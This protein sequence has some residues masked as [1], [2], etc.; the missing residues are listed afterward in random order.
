[1]RS[2]ETMHA[3]SRGALTVLITLGM[4]LAPGVAVADPSGSGSSSDGSSDGSPNAPGGDSPSGTAPTDSG[5]GAGG[6]PAP[7]DPGGP[8]ASKLGS[9]P[10]EMSPIDKADLAKRLAD[11]DAEV[12]EVVTL[13]QQV[14]SDPGFLPEVV[15]VVDD[16]ADVLVT[17]QQLVH[18]L[19]DQ[20]GITAPAA[21]FA[22]ATAIPPN[23][24][25][26]SLD[27]LMLQVNTDRQ[28]W[29]DAQVRAQSAQVKANS[30]N[31]AALKDKVQ[32]PNLSQSEKDA[33][34]AEIDSLTSA[35]QSQM[36][37]FQSTMDQYT[38]TSEGLA[39]WLAKDAQSLNTLTGN[40]R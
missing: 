3:L 40:L 22:P 36:I 39:N 29:L 33:I 27:Q 17:E 2:G 28:S 5:Q 12:A 11:I 31:L 25:N 18:A 21:P 37:E 20:Q 30:D 26:M 10:T 24:A 15:A 35:T 8:P 16:E 38:Q 14:D 32:D 6:G 23:Y 19:A 4:V 7:D 9:D 34:T 13:R 1:M